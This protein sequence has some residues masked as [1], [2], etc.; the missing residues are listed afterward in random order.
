MMTSSPSRRSRTCARVA[1]LNRSMRGMVEKVRNAN[2]PGKSALRR[3]EGAKR[4]KDLHFA[5]VPKGA[6][7]PKDLHFAVVLRAAKDLH[8]ADKC[9]SFAALRMTRA[10]L[11]AGEAHRC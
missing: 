8:F 11:V 9:R 1:C 10:V 7:R 5:V 2:G 6:K 4:P 3:P